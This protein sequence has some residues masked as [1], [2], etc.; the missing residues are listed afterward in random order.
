METR[1]IIRQAQ[2]GT[3]RVPA[4]V[5]VDPHFGVR[6]GDRVAYC[7]VQYLPSLPFIANMSRLD[8]WRE[9]LKLAVTGTVVGLVTN[10]TEPN[11]GPLT[12]EQFWA[13]TAEVD[14]DNSR[15]NRYIKAA[16]LA[17]EDTDHPIP[18]TT[19]EVQ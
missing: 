7:S 8:G 10:P 17:V 16:L 19:A 13:T 2:A 14:W 18:R 4:E 11:D 12:H 5:Q 15:A 6:V 3:L 1:E 9:W